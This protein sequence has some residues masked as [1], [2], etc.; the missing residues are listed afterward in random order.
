LR[1]WRKGEWGDIQGEA[2]EQPARRCRGFFGETEV[3]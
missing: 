3:E 2:L 1:R